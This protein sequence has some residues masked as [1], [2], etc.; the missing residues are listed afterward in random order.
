MASS[1][2]LLA[3]LGHEASSKTQL[4]LSKDS[5]LHDLHLHGPFDPPAMTG[6]GFAVLDSFSLVHLLTL[7][8]KR[9]RILDPALLCRGAFAPK[10][11]R[12]WAQGAVSQI[13]P[14]KSYSGLI[15][16]VLTALGAYPSEPPKLWGVGLARQVW[17]LGDAELLSH[18]CL[19]S[20]VM[21]H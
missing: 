13:R 20:E 2:T 15:G 8:R 5:P 14:I 11:Q 21:V 19:H 18:G 10:P 1:N 3:S 7:V 16:P 4:R 17:H 6:L 12:A 9:D